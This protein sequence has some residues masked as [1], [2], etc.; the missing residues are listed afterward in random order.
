M[1]LKWNRP[2]QKPGSKQVKVSLVDRGSLVA[3]LVYMPLRK[4]WRFSKCVGF[5]QRYYKWEHILELP[6]DTQLE[7]AKAAALVYYQ[8]TK[9][10]HE[11]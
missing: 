9:D 4:C 10:N 5:T 11:P 1:A 2:I 6:N 7:E 3:R 8:L